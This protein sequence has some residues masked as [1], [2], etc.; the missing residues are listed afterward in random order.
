MR[1]EIKVYVFED[2]I[3]NEVQ[4]KE[5]KQFHYNEHNEAIK[6]EDSYMIDSYVFDEFYDT[7][8][9]NRFDLK[10]EMTT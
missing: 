7:D 6:E 8:N 2:E 9:E 1:K 5:L 4:W 10:E 3:Y